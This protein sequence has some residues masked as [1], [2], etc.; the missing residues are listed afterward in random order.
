MNRSVLYL[1]IFFLFGLQYI[2]S[3]NS[4]A[5]HIVDKDNGADIQNVNIFITELQKGDGL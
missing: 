3:Q 1:L 4:I 2:Y 5:G